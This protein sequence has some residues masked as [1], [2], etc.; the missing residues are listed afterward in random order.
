MNKTALAIC[1]VMMMVGMAVVTTM[2]SPE[3]EGAS[4]TQ[5]SNY[6]LNTE[7]KSNYDDIE[8]GGMSYNYLCDASENKYLN[9]KNFKWS[10]CVIDAEVIE[11]NAFSNTLVKEIVLT[12]KVRRICTD[13][14]KDT[15]ALDSITR[16]G[17]TA[18][19][20]EDG[21]F[22]GC[23]GIKLLDLRH[24]GDV[25][26]NAF[27]PTINPRL[28]VDSETN[29]PDIPHHSLIV[30]PSLDNTIN[31][32]RQYV[33]SSINRL[34]VV[35]IGYG[36]LKFGTFDDSGV[37]WRHNYTWYG[38]HY[39]INNPV[40]GVSLRA[41]YFTV[42]VSYEA[43]GLGTQQVQMIDHNIKLETPPDFNDYDNFTGWTET[44]TET[45]VGTDID[46]F[47]LLTIAGYQ[48]TDSNR[49]ESSAFTVSPVVT[50]FTVRY[51]MTDVPGTENAPV[52][53]PCTMPY[54]SVYPA[55]RS[56]EHYRLAGW[57]VADEKGSFFEIGSTITE[58][59]DHTVKAVWE[60]KSDAIY[61]IT[62]TSS[63]G[64]VIGEPDT[65]AHGQTYV[66]DGSD[67]D[68][69]AGEQV[70]DGWKTAPDSKTLSIGS[71]IVVKGDLTLSP[72]LR[73]RMVYSV[74][75]VD[76][77]SQRF[78]VSVTEGETLRVDQ[79][80][81]DDSR[82]LAGWKTGAGT[83]LAIGDSLDVTGNCELTAVWKDRE[84]YEVRFVN[85]DEKISIQTAYE[86]IPL[87]I[88]VNVLDDGSRIF[89]GWRV[90]GS[91]TILNNGDVVTV[92][93]NLD[94][95]ATWRD[96]LP[97]DIYYYSEESRISKQIVS[98]GDTIVVHA[99]VYDPSR[100]LVGWRCGEETY[101]DGSEVTVDSDMVF[102][103]EWET[104]TKLSVTFI[105][106][107]DPV[108][109]QKNMG[110][111]IVVGVD[112]GR[113]DGMRFMGWSTT[114]DGEVEIQRADTVIVR[115]NMTLYPVYEESPDDTS[116]GSDPGTDSTTPGTSTD[117]DSTG[118]G[119]V[120]GGDTTD[121]PS[122]GDTDTPG[123]DG[124]DT[125]PDTPPGDSGD[126]DG[127]GNDKEPTNPGTSAD[128]DG[129]GDAPSDDDETPAG[130]SGDDGGNDQTPDGDGPADPSTPG[131]DTDN[132]DDEDSDASGEDASGTTAG[133]LGGIAD[134][135]AG[136]D[137]STTVAVIAS[138][139]A[140]VTCMMMV[141]HRRS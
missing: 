98:E 50:P 61:S 140:A 91:G 75:F 41:G 53:N 64:S 81:T 88:D 56:T 18:I 134:R 35:Y 62:Y 29:V 115:T 28:A 113:M 126:T 120:S 139:I 44:G 6:Q 110:E 105:T 93:K 40:D 96:R 52:L 90:N 141:I 72:S 54:G 94:I 137:Q 60:P 19:V 51:D 121:T 107:T 30:I 119:D 73:D 39:F 124:T 33:D 132:T 17:D 87:E 16:V 24:F 138:V 32:V 95:H 118:T 27:E 31:H 104:S 70:L 85:G 22:S 116:G 4:V 55:T 42:D 65:C 106:T 123:G 76:N 15:T 74:S 25:N 14:F 47:E 80:L 109:V 128:G 135:I 97:C 92:D 136:M 43:F 71:K 122:D 21:A 10:R 1:M 3:T 48:L 103:A 83:V 127:D 69:G 117:G 20:L 68:I 49:Q 23:T 114:V 112:P 67:L 86:G 129:N 9:V 78:L 101:A 5:Y 34:E 38:D 7:G 36:L 77:G 37:A 130:P 84:Q 58:L 63:D 57:T 133:I 108:V 12:E 79:N 59:R 125:D 99:T 46:R 26:V 11:A 13:A 111:P 100:E 8:F 2:S 82:I 102:I 45:S 89:M 131:T 66:I